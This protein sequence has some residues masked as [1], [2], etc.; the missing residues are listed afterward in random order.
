METL[1]NQD[2]R[3]RECA[4]IGVTDEIKGECLVVFCV[5][6]N[7]TEYVQ[8]GAILDQLKADVRRQ[9]VEELG[10]PLAPKEVCVVRSLPKTRNAKIMHR[11][12]RAAYEGQPLGDLSSLEDP[13]AI[14]DVRNRL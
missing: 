7:F 11:V 1:V 12:L 5:P 2:V 10:K 8:Q 9:L 13:A 3:I 14:E 4:A 6:S